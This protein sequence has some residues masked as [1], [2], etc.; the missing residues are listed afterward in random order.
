MCG[1]FVTDISDIMIDE[2]STWVAEFQTGIARLR[3]QTRAGGH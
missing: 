1:A 3:G 2:T